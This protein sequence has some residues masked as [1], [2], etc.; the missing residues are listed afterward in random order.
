M[1][2][3]CNFYHWELEYVVYLLQQN[4]LRGD[5]GVDAL[6]WAEERRREL[7]NRPVDFAQ[8]PASTNLGHDAVMTSNLN[9]LVKVLI[10]KII[11]AL[12]GLLCVLLIVKK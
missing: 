5:T 9:S 11:I 10:L 3:G 2:Q 8:E 7:M 12:L 1:Q 6:G 4:M